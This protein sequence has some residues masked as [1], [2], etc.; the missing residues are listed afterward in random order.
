MG[1]RTTC[2][3]NYL[4]IVEFDENI[5]PIRYCGS[6]TPAEYKGRSNRLKIRYKTSSNLA[7]TGW[8]INFMAVHENTAIS[9]F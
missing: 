5:P 7:G 3:L 8:I 2:E 6:D 9:K 4:E 1:P